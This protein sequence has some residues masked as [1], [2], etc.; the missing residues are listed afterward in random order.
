MDDVCSELLTVHSEYDRSD[1]MMFDKN[2]DVKLVVIEIVPQ[3]VGDAC[4]LSHEDIKQEFT[5]AFHD[6]NERNETNSM[7]SLMSI[8]QKNVFALCE[9]M[10][11]CQV[12]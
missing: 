4:E 7:D 2:E 12:W 8:E 5:T 1:V 10:G 6:N 9:N 3:N 11:D